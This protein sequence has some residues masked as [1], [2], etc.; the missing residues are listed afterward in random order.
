M[1]SGSSGATASIDYPFAVSLEEML[2]ARE[3]GT[4]LK[5]MAMLLAA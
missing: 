1:F 5:R 2:L 4:A 3:V